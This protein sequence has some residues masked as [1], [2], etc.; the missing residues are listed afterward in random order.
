M[1][2]DPPPVAPAIRRPG[3]SLQSRSLV[4]ATCIAALVA[5]F[6]FAF[7]PD[8]RL[9][10][11]YMDAVNP[12]YIIPGILDPA[13]PGKRP[14]ILPGNELG[15][16][17]PLFTGTLYHGSTQLYFALPW[18]MMFGVD[19]GSLRAIQGIVGALIVVLIALFAFRLRAGAPIAA[20]VTT[21][22]LLALD[23]SFVM[24]LRAQAYSCLFPLLP[25]LG[26]AL[27]L[28]DWGAKPRAALRLI[29]SGILLGLAIFSY[30]IFVFFFPPLLWLLLRERPRAASGDLRHPL[31]IWLLAVAVG[32][33]PFLVGIALIAHELRGI[34]PLVEWLRTHGNQMHMLGNNDGLLDRVAAVLTDARSV[35]TGK[36][37]W[38]MILGHHSGDSTGSLKAGILIGLPLA[39]LAF[40]RGNDS[41]RSAVGLPLLFAFAFLAIAMIFGERLDGHHYTAILPFFYA[42]FGCTCAMLW[43]RAFRTEAAPR[44]RRRALVGASLATLCA[45]VV[46]GANLLNL[47]RFHDDLR[48]SGGAALYSDAIDRFALDVLHHDADASVYLPDWGF[49]MPFTFITRA[50]VVQFDNVDPVRMH[51]EGCTGKP[52]IVLFGGA[53]N[54]AKFQLVAKLAD[55]PAGEVRTWSQRDGKPVFETMRFEGR[56]NCTNETTQSIRAAPLENADRSSIEVTPHAAY[57]CAFLA[58]LV[59]SVRWDANVASLIDA[60]VWITSA[61]R[62]LLRW[63]HGPSRGSDRTGRWATPG[64]GFVLIDP[65][66]GE[67]L[68]T[69]RIAALDCPVH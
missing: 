30:F 38:L 33:L 32:Y 19:V 44:A 66:T 36:W 3:A 51:D 55:L 34:H 63:T 41:Q 24:G 40:E 4:L 20:F 12:E 43:H 15:G 14:W 61:E 42:A 2:V 46:A 60:E 47:V 53:G 13:A 48:A 16:R 10:G 56:G 62:P 29:A 57:A 65:D 37:P 64:M 22:A 28:L 23:P 58:P 27:L 50:R 35:V 5:V 59:A 49:V 26:S 21:G 7:A 25:L 54:A 39:T 6:A 18:M 68:A 31:A 67:H 11:L 69:T 52:Q 17:F 8:W 9:P 1:T 45:V